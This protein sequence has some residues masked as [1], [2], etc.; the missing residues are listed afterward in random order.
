MREVT[1][2]HD[3]QYH[4]KIKVAGMKIRGPL[5]LL[6]FIFISSPNGFTQESDSLN[7][8]DVLKMSL[9]DLMNTR[10]VS[11]SKSIQLVKDVPA[12]VRVIT[13]EQIKDRAYFT[14]EEALADLPDFQ[15]R[16]I[17]G[18]NSYVFMRGATSQNNLILL[19][20]DGIQINELNSGGFYAG[21]QFILSDVEQIEVVYGPASALY[22]TN[23]VSGIIN[24]ITKKPEINGGH[25]RV[26]GGN[27]KT[28]MMNFDIG[29]Y[30]K[31]KDF[32]ILVSGQY[33]TT[34]KADLRGSEGDNN[35]TNNMENFEN[36]LSFSAKL[37]LKKF[38][39][40]IIYQEKRSSMTTNFRTI[41]DISL[42]KNT[43]WDIMFLNGWVKYTNTDHEKWKFN[44]TLYY[45]NSTV[46]PNTI[47][48]IIMATDSTP[49][50]QVGYY[51]PNSLAGMENQLDFYPTGR[52]HF[53]G[54]LITEAEVLS[55]GYS[56]T[57][58]GSQDTRP[59]K[60]PAPPLLH[61]YLL[62][63][64]LQANLS[65]ARD[66]SVIGGIRHD[67]SSYYGQVLIPRL[68]IVF[69]REK[70]AAKALYN[71]AFRSPKPWDFQYGTGNP[72]LRPEKMKS[73]ELIIAWQTLKELSFTGSVFNNLIT[74][75]LTKETTP[76]IDRWINKDKLNT[77]GFELSGNFNTGKLQLY[78]DYSFND[79][80]DMDNVSIPEISKHTANAGFT[81]A[82]IDRMKIN[83]RANYLGERKNPFIIPATGDYRID[84]ALIFNGCVS[85]S[86]F[87]CFNL[88]FKMNNILNA[89]YYHPSNRFNGRY[90]QPQ[91]TFSLWL[92]YEFNFKN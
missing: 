1:C 25:V 90:R 70:F 46:L 18:F 19:L 58:S 66:L 13:A 45:R 52:L 17:V 81:W 39:A 27:F 23:A 71:T 11:A 87:R 47:D 43:L 92:I 53:T 86:L 88:S 82:L 57:Y 42:D 22:G 31:S 75:K 44:S 67:F 65:I 74:D 69:N 60:P 55:N 85:Y 10:V 2:I 64:Y 48:Q 5:L 28:G 16:N 40:G 37:K 76:T 54:G 21:G 14:L 68:G 3:S 79:S 30:S 7:Y 50:N 26:L 91:R 34:E 63:Y 89:E 6:L 32:G 12:A 49:G 35:W 36:D 15:F 77:T 78:A 24:I 73:L 84:D 62:S 61:N 51:R 83:L 29:R 38:T 4:L 80:R 56:I 20:V 9:A 59:P 72:D 33:R 41:G 8:E